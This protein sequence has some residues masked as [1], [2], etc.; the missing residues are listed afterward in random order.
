MHKILRISIVAGLALTAAAPGPAPTPSYHLAEPIAVPA[1]SWDY[2]RVDPGAHRLYVARSGSVTVVDLASGTATSIGAIQRGHAVVPLPGGRLLVTSGNDATV[3]ILDTAD[4]HEQATIPVGKKPDAAIYD[5]ATGHAYVMNAADGSVSVVDVAAMR[6][7]STI[8]LKPGLEYA[9]LGKDGTLYVNNEDANEI[10]VVD[11]RHGTVSTPIALAGCE[12]PSGLGYDAIHNRL[13]SACANGKAAIVDVAHRRLIGLIDIGQGPDAVI[14]DT[15]RRLALIPCGK[16][17]V[18][19]V[20]SLDGPRGVMR[21]G[22]IQ[23]EVGARTGA[24]DPSTGAVYLP[25]ARF[26]PPAHPGDRPAA[27]PGSAHVVVVRPG[28]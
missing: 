17:G 10:E 4:G 7:I 11:L 14:M 15:A 3:R 24:L 9:A 12:E 27:I 20:L 22:N 25:T 26:T 21:A 6:V 16:D 8:Q 28:A 2:A 19:D 5:A 13:I 23:T 1:G 18:L